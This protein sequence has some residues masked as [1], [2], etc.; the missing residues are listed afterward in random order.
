MGYM[1]LGAHAQGLTTDMQM[2]VDRLLKD[3]SPKL[4]L[5]KIGDNDPALHAGLRFNPPRTYGVWEE[6]VARGETNW[7]FT[8]AEISITPALLVRVAEGDFAK[9]N[10]G[11]K[12]DQFQARQQIAEALRLKEQNDHN[13]ERREEMILTGKA[14]RRAGNGTAR[15]RIN[16]EDVLVGDT[17]T[18]V[19]KFIT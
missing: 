12:F 1:D 10:A 13:A 18:P 16:G 6:P 8:V 15:V 19:R 9:T 7:V 2:K 17:I 4:S 3:Y 14:M 11:Q 5:R